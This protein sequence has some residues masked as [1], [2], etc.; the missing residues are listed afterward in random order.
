MAFTDDGATS[1]A[2]GSDGD[3]QTVRLKVLIMN[4]ENVGSLCVIKIKDRPIKLKDV[5]CKCNQRWS[6]FSLVERYFT[7]TPEES[8]WWTA[9]SEYCFGGASFFDAFQNLQF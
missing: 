5:S 2:C 8:D 1:S 9:S 3:E 7:W 4:F 6:E